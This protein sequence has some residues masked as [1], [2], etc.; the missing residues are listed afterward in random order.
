MT[1]FYLPVLRVVSPLLFLV[2]RRLPQC[3]RRHEGAL[4]RRER[5]SP[6][7]ERK[8][9]LRFINCALESDLEKCL[10]FAS[11]T[12][13]AGFD[14]DMAIACYF[15]EL[16]DPARRLIE[17]SIQWVQAAIDGKGCE[18]YYEPEW[19]E[20][21]RFETLAMCNWFLTGRH[22][23][24]NHDRFV[25]HYDRYLKYSN[26]LADRVNTSLILPTYLDHGLYERVLEI[27]AATPSL[28]PPEPGAA[29]RSEA[30]AC[31]AIAKQRLD[32][33][34]LSEDVRHAV[35]RFLRLC[36]NELI[37]TA[38]WTRA[39]RWMKIVH[40]NAAPAELSPKQV[41]MKCYDYLRGVRPPS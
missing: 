2:T 5:F 9:L 18:H 36:V 13:T 14:L 34:V 25:Y 29:L 31:Y 28:T 27:F 1:C 7:Q 10:P 38:A 40:W 15:T 26:A 20:A 21:D 32:H 8:N 22:D 37:V 39:A 17:K 6:K 4:V 19:T 12:S 16:D 3:G 11:L 35:G 24:E 33:G 23:S 30:A 41:V